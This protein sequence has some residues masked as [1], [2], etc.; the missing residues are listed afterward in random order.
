MPALIPATTPV[1]PPIVATEVLL[2]DHEPPAGAH[3]RTVEAPTQTL[4]P[5]IADGAGF[6]VSGAVAKHPVDKV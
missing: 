4:E 5:P 2:L 6:T 1:V 3:D